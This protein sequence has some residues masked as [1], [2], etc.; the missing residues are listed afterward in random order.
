M[1]EL[2]EKILGNGLIF[3]LVVF[4]IGSSLAFL[5]TLPFIIKDI[6]DERKRIKNTKVGRQVT[7]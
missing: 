4:S 6:V 7:A 2:L 3:S 1:E 5:I